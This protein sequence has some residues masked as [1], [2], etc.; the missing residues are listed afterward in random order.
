MSGKY[1]SKVIANRGVILYFVSLAVVICLV[2]FAAGIAFDS[3]QQAEAAEQK[4][5]SMR[6]AADIYAEKKALLDKEAARPIPEAKIDDVQTSVLSQIQ[7]HGLELA[8]MSSPAQMDKEKDRVYEMELRG[9]YDN[10][11]EFLSTFRQKTKALI[12]ILSVSF[13]PDKESIRTSV[14]YKLYVR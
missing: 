3:Y 13:Q 6:K 8:Q 7:R 10:T 4:I 11:M 2:V 9:S 12:A 1:F 14:K 5:A